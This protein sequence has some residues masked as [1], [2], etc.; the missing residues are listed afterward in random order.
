MEHIDRFYETVK[1]EMAITLATEADGRVTMRTVSPVLYGRHILMFTSPDSLKY[2]QLK[3]NPHCCIAAGGFFAEATSVC[4]GSTMLD[5]NEKLRAAYSE[6]FP[7]AFD[8]GIE[9]GGRAAVFILLTPT[10]LTGWAFENGV[11][12]PDGVPTVP[13]DIALDTND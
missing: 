6:K 1:K 4:L 10:R 2:R 5:A 13:F 11:P 3:A 8:D 7:G 9:F 12:T